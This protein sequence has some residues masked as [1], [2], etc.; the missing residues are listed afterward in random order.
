MNSR[1]QGAGAAGDINATTTGDIRLDNQAFINTSTTEEGRGGR[2]QLQANSLNLTNGAGLDSRSQGAGA[3]G[4][5]NATTTEDIR[6]DNQAFINTSTTEEGRG[7]RIQLQ[8]NSLNLTNGAELNSRT[9][10]AGAAGDIDVTTT[11][12][13]RLDSQAFINASTTEE[14]RGGRIQLQANSLNLINGAELNSRSEGAGAA[15]DIGVTTTG[16]IRL[17]SQAFINASTTEEGRGGGIEVQANSLNLTNGAGLDSRTGGA[18]A[19]GDIDV[20]TTGDIRLDNQAFI[21]A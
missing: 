1:S 9:G 17:D 19:A 2:I 12:D 7:G 16:D 14:G 11:G 6:L 3:A 8:A 5:I 21:N 10:G 20:T 15:G 4:D 18:G 13:I